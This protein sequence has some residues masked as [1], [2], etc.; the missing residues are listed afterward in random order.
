MFW[1]SLNSQTRYS[2]QKHH[3]NSDFAKII[4]MMFLLI[5]PNP[6]FICFSFQSN[7]TEISS[8]IVYMPVFT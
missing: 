6:L 3:L 1:N 5:V 7:G 4:E 8:E 2:K